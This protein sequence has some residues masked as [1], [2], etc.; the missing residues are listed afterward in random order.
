MKKVFLLLTVFTSF[1][2]SKCYYASC[3][4]Q[5]QSGKAQVEATINSGFSAI[6]NNLAE[7]IKELR[8]Q[9]ALLKKEKE[10]LSE[11]VG[12]LA[13]KAKQEKEI[14][15]LMEKYNKLLSNKISERSLND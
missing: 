13:N 6:E 5:I 15:F 3:H 7:F 9:D 11:Y 10:V 12:I 4:W 2:F 14:I 8:K 1:A